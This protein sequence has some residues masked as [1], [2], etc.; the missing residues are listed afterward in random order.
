VHTQSLLLSPILEMS[1]SQSFTLDRRVARSRSSIHQ[2]TARVTHILS[3]SRYVTLSG[4]PDYLPKP[5]RHRHSIWLE[6]Q[7]IG[8]S[9]SVEMMY[10]GLQ[11][12]ARL[13]VDLWPA[14]RSHTKGR[15]FRT[16]LAILL[17]LAHRWVLLSRRLQVQYLRTARRLWTYLVA[18]H[19]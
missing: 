13:L 16:S 15:S 1:I 12:R 14:R 19:I 5:K 10:I 18:R 4:I 2:E 11:K 7:I 8:M 3:L 9:F 17:L 6:L